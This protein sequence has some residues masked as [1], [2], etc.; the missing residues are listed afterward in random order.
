MTT[1]GAAGASVS[2]VLLGLV[3]CGSGDERGRGDSPMD[4]CRGGRMMAVSDPPTDNLITSSSS[5]V[6]RLAALR[7]GT[8]IRR[9]MIATT[10]TMLCASVTFA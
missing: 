7:P 6:Q 3:G 1:R 10:D 4:G 2:L 9:V 8:F 5:A